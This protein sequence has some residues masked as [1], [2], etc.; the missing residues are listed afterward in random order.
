MG[1][2]IV[3][4]KWGGAVKKVFW[5][6]RQLGKKATAGP[7]SQPTNCFEQPAAQSDWLAGFLARRS[8]FFQLPFLLA[9]AAVSAGR[10]VCRGPPR[11]RP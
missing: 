7:E 5:Q 6:Q 4:A 3:K 1:I 9:R 10:G 8:L 2:L 11:H